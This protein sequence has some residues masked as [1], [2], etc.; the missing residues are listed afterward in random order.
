MYLF[1]YFPVMIFF[2]IDKLYAFSAII[3]S[4]LLDIF[5]MNCN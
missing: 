2:F 5:G 4:T 3:G 1:L